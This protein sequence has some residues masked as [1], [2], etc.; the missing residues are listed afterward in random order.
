VRLAA[1]GL[2]AGAV[3]TIDEALV[4]PQLLHTRAVGIAGGHRVARSAF[5]VDG[6]RADDS[7]APPALGED[8]AAVLEEWLDL[9]EKRIEELAAAGAFGSPGSG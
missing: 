6:E 5:V 1:A 7:S 3:Q 4:H 8:T 2:P 9:D